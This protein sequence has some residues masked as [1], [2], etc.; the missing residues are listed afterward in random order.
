MKKIG[1]RKKGEMSQNAAAYQL[2]S[3]CMGMNQLINLTKMKD[4]AKPFEQFELIDRMKSALGLQFQLW[5][6][7]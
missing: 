3:Y 7:I 6:N 5:R 2:K 4:A 1:K